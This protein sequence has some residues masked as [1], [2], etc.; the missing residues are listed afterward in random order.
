MKSGELSNERS[1]E[2]A[3]RERT[4]ENLIVWQKAMDL[5]GNDLSDHSE[6]FREKKSM[7]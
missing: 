7:G 6:P 1:N 5:G 2:I 3:S 4:I